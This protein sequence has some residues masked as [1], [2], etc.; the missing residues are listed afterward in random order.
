[1]E[2]FQVGEEA[3]VRRYWEG[4]MPGKDTAG[5]HPFSHTLFY[6]FRLANP[7]LYQQSNK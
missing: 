7:E 1:M 2:G 4:G 6:A 3:L 5:L